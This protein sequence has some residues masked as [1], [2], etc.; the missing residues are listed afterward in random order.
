MEVFSRIG[1]KSGKNKTQ[2]LKQ[3]SPENVGSK[4]GFLP[5]IYHVGMIIKE[6]IY[7]TM[8]DVDI[9]LLFHLR[10]QA[11]FQ[12]EKPDQPKKKK[13]DIL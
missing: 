3:K 2:G 9:S 7:N 6:N 12:M 10:N 4:S 11:S 8:F 5:I 13:N 1:T